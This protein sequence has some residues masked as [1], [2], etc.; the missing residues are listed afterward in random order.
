MKE[1]GGQKRSY[2]M[3]PQPSDGFEWHLYEYEIIGYDA[4]ALYRLEVKLAS[5]KKSPKGK[6]TKD[7][8]ADLQKKMGRLTAD[9]PVDNKSS[10]KGKIKTNEK[11]D[12]ANVNSSQNEMTSTTEIL[13]YG[14]SSPYK[15]LAD[16]S[17][18]YDHKY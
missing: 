12:S 6:V 8:L 16:N 17:A 13:H 4:Y 11:V 5:E 7:S 10:F 3:D 9:V 1:F 15:Y 2:Y 18:D 14:S